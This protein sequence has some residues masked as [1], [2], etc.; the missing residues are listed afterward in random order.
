MFEFDEPDHL[1]GPVADLHRHWYA[2]SGVPAHRLVAGSFVL[3]DPRLA[4]RT[5]SVP[6]WTTFALERSAQALERYL[7]GVEPYDEVRDALF[8]HGMMSIGVAPPERWRPILARA[9]KKG[10]FLG[11][12]PSAFPE[13][14]AVF[15]RFHRAFSALPERHPV[16]DP[17]PLNEALQMIR[18][19]L[20]PHSSEPTRASPG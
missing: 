2:R 14:F 6:F 8:A 11:T 20:R 9:R 4:A 15:A 13:D 16:P 17:L 5:R 7:D 10:A 3:L 18:S 19:A 1:A 12:Q